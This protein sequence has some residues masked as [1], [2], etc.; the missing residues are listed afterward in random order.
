MREFWTKMWERFRTI[1]AGFLHF[2]PS[3][4]GKVKKANFVEGV[5]KIRMRLT[6]EEIGQIWA[7]LDR[8]GRGYCTFN[9][10]TLLEAE[11]QSELLQNTEIRGEELVRHGHGLITLPSDG[12]KDL[13]HNQFCRR[14][15]KVKAR[16]DSSLLQHKVNHFLFTRSSAFHSPKSQ[17]LREQMGAGYHRRTVASK[18]RSETPWP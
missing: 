7:V 9:D 4:K 17:T 3:M 6:A 5:Q 11:H 2:D 18:L 8:Q 15:L 16:R 14:G 1:S 13:I 10:F 12:I